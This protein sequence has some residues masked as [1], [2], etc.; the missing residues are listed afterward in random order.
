VSAARKD[1]TKLIAWVARDTNAPHSREDGSGRALPTETNVESGT[2][3]SK[4]G[5]SVNSGNNGDLTKQ[6][7]WVARETNAPQ[8]STGIP[9]AALP[10]ET[11]VESGASQ[12]KSGTSVN[13]SNSGDQMERGRVYGDEPRRALRT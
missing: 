9:F 4:S 10:A 5:T 12:S 2:S 7:A 11:K 1:F 3:Q 6:I 13:L 8:G